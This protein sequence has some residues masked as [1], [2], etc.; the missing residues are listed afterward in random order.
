M[1]FY[2]VDSNSLYAAVVISAVLDK[3]KSSARLRPV[4]TKRYIAIKI[5]YRVRYIILMIMLRV[6]SHTPRSMARAQI[7]KSVSTVSTARSAT[8]P[9]QLPGGCQGAAIGPHGTVRST[10]Y[11][12][13]DALRLPL[14]LL[15]PVLSA[16][17]RSSS[18]NTYLGLG[19][20]LGLGLGLRHT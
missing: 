7:M 8:S 18:W 16:S 19:S 5:K 1:S 2:V 3:V 17:R 10:R 15:L 13:T 11:T 12:C 20:G 6:K 4:V 14:L 9:S